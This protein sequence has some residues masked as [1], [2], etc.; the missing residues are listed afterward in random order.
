MAAFPGV[1]EYQR[2][3]AATHSHLG[4]LLRTLRQR[5]ASRTEYETA[6][7]LFSKLSAAYPTVP[8]YQ[9]HLGCT[10]CCLGKLLYEEGQWAESLHSYDLSIRTLTPVYEADPRAQKARLDLQGSQDSR[11]KAC[12]RLKKQAES[13][14]DGGKATKAERDPAN[15]GYLLQTQGKWEEALAAY[16]EGLRLKPDN[17]WL[18]DRLA[19]LLANRPEA[20]LRDPKQAVQLAKR[21]VVLAPHD[22]DYWCTLGVAHYRA[23]NWKEAIAALRKSMER[24]QGG[25]GKDWFFLAM[26]HWQLGEKDKARAWYD[27]AVPCLDRNPPDVE[28]L[29]RFRAEAAERL[30]LEEKK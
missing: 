24:G 23:E 2:N 10:F 15:R 12:D 5:D 3:L 30:G 25:D 26:A 9:V 27:R 21:A 28:E 20:R 4:A 13:A 17:A 14:K 22:G 7:D 29:R 11:A 6:R 1:P 18:H 19:W 16:R 8:Q